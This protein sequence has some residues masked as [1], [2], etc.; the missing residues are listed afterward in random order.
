[1]Q[2]ATSKVSELGEATREISNVSQVITDIADQT[3]LLALNATIEGARGGE[4]G[5]AVVASEIKEL[6]K[7]TQQAT[8]QIKARIE[9]IQTSTDATVEEVGLIT[10]VISDVESIMGSIAISMTEQS[11]R[12][13]EVA[14]NIE[15][16]SSG[17]A[18]VNENVAQSS[19]VSAQIAGDIADVN[20][21]A[22]NISTRSS[23]MCSSSEGLSD[24]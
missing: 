10:N 23:N 4:K 24:L 9:S 3:N 11:S 2:N 8:Q 6:A 18:E 1:M 15:Q 5:F 19:T 21:V 17:I 12:A 13:A 22:V 7:Q 16:A 14:Q 20:S